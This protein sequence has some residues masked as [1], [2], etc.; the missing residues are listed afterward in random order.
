MMNPASWITLELEGSGAR[1]I[2]AWVTDETAGP[3]GAVRT[4]V[5]RTTR[6]IREREQE[7]TMSII[8]RTDAEASPPPRA[9]GPGAARERD[10]GRSLLFGLLALQNDFVDREALLAAFNAWVA[11]K[12]RS[13][14]RILLERG[15]LDEEAHGLLEAL[16]RKHLQKHGDAEKSLAAADGLGALRAELE[17]AADPEIRA[18]LDRL[19]GAAA[20][21][22][23]DPD[24]TLTYSQGPPA[25]GSRF[26]ILRPHARGGLGQI[27][28]ALD[29]ELNREVALK[30][31]RPE[32]AD[33]PDSRARFLLEAEITGRLEHPGVV[34]VYGLGNDAQARPFYAMRLV[35]G[36]SLKEAIER[37]HQAEGRDGRDRRR[38]NL[39][40]RQLLNRFVA[41]CNVM[42]YA[43]SRGVIHRDLKP[44]NILL[45]PYGETLVVDWGLAKVV[46][47]GEAAAA[48][49]AVEA[50][51]QPATGSGSS[52]TLPGTALGTPAYMSPEQAEGRLERVGPRS[53]VYS[54]GATLYC[55][56]TG[57]PPIDETDI[58]EAL[59]QVQRGEFPPPRAARPSIPH[60]LEAICLKAMALKP[61]DRYGSA[62]A[63]AE[64]IEHW[65]ADEPIA[66]ARDPVLTRL[67][68]WG[69]RHKT[70]AASLG[71]LLVTAVVALAISTILIGREQVRTR[72]MA[73]D[74]KR[75]DYIHRV[76]LA[77]GEIQDDNIVRAEDLLEGCPAGLRGWEWHYVRRLGHRELRTY[78][79]H[80]ENACCLAISPDGEWVASGAVPSVGNITGWVFDAPGREDYRSEV[81]LW[82]VETGQER[83]VFGGLPGL[84][85][86]VAISPDGR[87]VA[88][89]GGFSEPRVEGWLKVWDARSG[90]LIWGPPVPGTMVLGLAFRPDG[91]SLAVGY[92]RFQDLK[93]PGYVQLHRVTDGKPL[94]GAF[95]KLVSGVNVVAFD[96]GGRRLAVAG[97]E[98]I[99]IWDPETRDRVRP[100]TEHATLA[101]CIAFH[102][103]GKRRASG[104]PDHT[105]DL[106]DLAS[107][108]IVQTF[109]GHRG[110][111]A[112]I[113]FSPD[114]QQLASVSMDKSV[115]LWEVATGRELAAFHGHTH[116]VRAL[117]FHPDGRRLVSGSLDGTVKVWDTVTSRPIALRGHSNPVF[118]VGFGDDDR[119]VVSKSDDLTIKHWD[120][121]TVEEDR[122]IPPRER[123]GPPIPANG[124][125]PPPSRSRLSPD[126]KLLAEVKGLDVEVRRTA[127]GTVAF[128]L[129]GH[130]SEILDVVFSP[131]G[132]RIATASN[133]RTIK[134]WDVA[135]GLEALT[136]RGH[137]AGVFCVAFSPDGKRLASGGMDNLVLV[138]DATPLPEAVLT[139]ARAHRLVQF[140]MI[141]WPWKGE[142]IAQLRA[143]PDLEEPTRAAALRIAGQ[144][145]DQPQ[146]ERLADIWTIVET[147]GRD[148]RDYQRALRRAEECLRL[149]AAPDGQ[150]LHLLGFAYYRAGRLEDAWDTFERAEPMPLNGSDGFAPVR[151]VFRV[152]IL[153]HQGRRAEARSRLDQFRRQFQER[154]PH[155]FWAGSLLREAEALID[156]KPAGDRGPVTVGPPR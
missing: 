4:G 80:F 141:E 108:A 146:P 40:L 115:R 48:A 46:G 3:L 60:G 47:R 142:L 64:E 32:R 50:T 22:R 27:S 62:R 67:A 138:W 143:D 15:A 29:A 123:G 148:P 79:G 76:N 137:T 69:R 151:D 117:A 70:A 94:G 35:K 18:T 134:L 111:V 52:E 121:D 68:R 33:D 42:A 8:S 28:V 97:P 99:E 133:D 129:E 30:E 37:F 130:T 34:P 144:L 56:L 98:R 44:A 24:A 147:P 105:I 71:A 101:Y 153:H 7:G 84:V 125:G 53:D 102:P 49:G 83:H 66:A 21:T 156:P 26:A 31:I 89:G 104:G 139:E 116:F 106:R 36:Q 96:R 11:D 107:G 13:L 65:L 23:R 72:E 136:L 5:E 88:A 92:V 43:H 51:L 140:R 57:K 91:R 118:S 110:P 54:L 127:S 45:G 2:E 17:R 109:S 78:R 93:H 86:A 152:M 124:G 112:A 74:L 58:A 114:G 73:E 103:D 20:A 19:P 39:A 12:S 82:S 77:H 6:R 154:R 87:L 81:R 10:T 55:L 135:T 120:L 38:W 90:E 95:G 100:S 126:G 131:D 1:R 113:A 155:Y 122:A 132:T 85:R 25:A 59:R 145:T 14:G 128:T 119:H 41:V 9:R 75:K 63:L 16:V 149:R 150:T 61:E